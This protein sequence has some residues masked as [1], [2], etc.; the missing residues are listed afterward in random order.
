MNGE[1]HI[2]ACGIGAKMEGEGVCNLVRVYPQS[3]YANTV[4]GGQPA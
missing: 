4:K 3:P 2:D 1:E